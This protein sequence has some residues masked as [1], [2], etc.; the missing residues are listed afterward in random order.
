MYT[1]QTR[2]CAGE[3]QLTQQGLTLGASYLSEEGKLRPASWHCE[4]RSPTLRFGKMMS[5]RVS[6]R[7]HAQ[8]Y[9]VLVP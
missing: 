3:E 5:L 9:T 4:A 6:F 2:E 7:T 1:P 8:S